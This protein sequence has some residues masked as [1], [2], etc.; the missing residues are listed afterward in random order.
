[1]PVLSFY[2]NLVEL[3]YYFQ[4]RSMST[5]WLDTTVNA[6][7]I[8]DPCSCKSEEYVILLAHIF[9]SNQSR[10]Q[11]RWIGSCRQTWT[12]LAPKNS[13]RHQKKKYFYRRIFQSFHISKNH[14][15]TTAFFAIGLNR[16]SLFFS[17]PV[18]L[19]TYSDPR[20]F[21]L[22]GKWCRSLPLV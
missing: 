17:E 3:G 8:F 22:N 19:C 10:C 2:P 11:K 18:D 20:G 9:C 13:G 4:G 21:R 7:L 14:L 16:E 12:S 15:G 1:M 5:D 6:N